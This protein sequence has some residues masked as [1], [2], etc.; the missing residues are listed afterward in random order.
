MRREAREGL[1]AL[2]INQPGI[3]ADHG[4]LHGLRFVPR[5]LVTP[6]EQRTVVTPIISSH[7]EAAVHRAEAGED[8]ASKGAEAAATA[9]MGG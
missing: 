3:H 6:K 8:S 5:T 2:L 4:L 7:K 1:A 9:G